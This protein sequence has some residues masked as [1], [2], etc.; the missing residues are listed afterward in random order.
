[1]SISVVQYVSSAAQTTAT[2]ASATISSTGTGNCLVVV[3]FTEDAIGTAP[4]VSS[5]QIGGVADNFSSA[6][7]TPSAGG[8]LRTDL[9][10]DRNALSGQTSVTVNLTSTTSFSSWEFKVY[11]IS[12]LDTASPVDKTSTNNTAGA[13][14]TSGT[15]AT[16]T[17]AS[18]IWIGAVFCGNTATGPSSPW[19]NH[20]SGSST[21]I[22][23]FQIVSSM[24]TATY[25]GTQSSS[26]AV[27]AA[28]ITLKGFT[29]VTSTGSVALP[30]MALSATVLGGDTTTSGSVTLKTMVLASTDS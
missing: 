7:T 13:S 16:T 23:G 28:V 3:V 17:A 6:A 11:E 21:D 1:M 24:G 4:T 12:G 27:A 8:N 5:V 15:T 2:S 20:N 25:S 26:G 18:E 10:V 9:W 19:T 29:N 14:W 30:R 22:D